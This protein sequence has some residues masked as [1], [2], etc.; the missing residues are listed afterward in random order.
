M[1]NT[2][3]PSGFL[4]IDKPEGPT[5]H[6]CI[7]ALR[8][9]TGIKKIGHAGT[10]D[11][12]ATGLL[13]IGVGA[14]T[15]LLGRLIGLDKRYDATVRL[16]AA[17]TTDDRTGEIVS[18]AWSME[19]EAWNMD[20]IEEILKKFVGEIEQIPPMYSAKK[21]GG[22]KLYE[23]ARKGINI[24]RAPVRVRIHELRV[25]SYEWPSR[26]FDLKNLTMQSGSRPVSGLLHLAIHCSKGTYIRALARDIG[27]VLGVGGY[28]E[29]LRRT[30]IGPFRI[31]DALPLST[32]TTQN[33]ASFLRTGEFLLRAA[34]PPPESSESPRRKDESV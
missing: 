29:E 33:W 23:L 17:S 1:L 30:A 34:A 21:I 25:L 9:I 2:Y 28:L 7:D 4:L 20:D 32:I 31:T 6:D 18:A 11:P 13:I 22:K 12:F 27:D 3:S 14:S 16:G 24:E 8:R 5:S 26:H 10:L 15:K 19:H